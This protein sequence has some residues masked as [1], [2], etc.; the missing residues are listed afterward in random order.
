M[1]HMKEPNPREGT[2]TRVVFH[3]WCNNHAHERT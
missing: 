2:E 3:H 1:N